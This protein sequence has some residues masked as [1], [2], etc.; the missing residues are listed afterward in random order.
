MILT[1]EQ[2]DVIEFALKNLQGL[3][4]LLAIGGP[5]GSGKTTLIKKLVADLQELGQIV[6]V[7]AAT[8]KAA[9]V[10]RN[11]GIQATSLHQACMRPI[12]KPPLNAL[13]DCLY[14]A[15]RESDDTKIKISKELLAQYSLDDL[16]KGFQKTRDSGIYTAL[17]FLGITD[18]FK[19][20]DGWS[21]AAE[22]A[23]V[24]IIDEASMVGET[25]L[26]LARQVFRKVILVGDSFQLPPVSSKPVFWEITLRKELTTIHRQAKGSQPL[27]LATKIRVGEPVTP[28]PIEAVDLALAKDGMPVICWKNQTRVALTTQ[29][30]SKLGYANKGPQP[31]ESL[32]C[33]NGSDRNAKDRGLINN[34]IWKVV[35]SNGFTCTLQN[36]Q[37]EILEDEP[38]FIEEMNR[39]EGVP[40]RFAY[41]L[42][43][44]NSQG[45]EWPVVSIHE[46]DAKEFFR[47]KRQEAKQWLYTALTRA[48]HTIKWVN[49]VA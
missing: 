5:A 12:F 18:S 42:T 25:E 31:G 19:Y 20:L 49:R 47:F 16:L 37:G 21:A 32:I 8:N 29:I 4:C 33:R 34:T 30:R 46:P 24:L 17:R 6:V 36:D 3:D 45:S 39:G 15:I 14:Q 40:F 43:A 13:S 2:E 28:S 44:H 22:T 35:E 27:E 38:V 1:K 7:C 23:G 48:Q 26:K 9:L 41:V 11:K 10:L